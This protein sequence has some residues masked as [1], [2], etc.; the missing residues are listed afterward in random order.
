MKPENQ[1][2]TSSPAPSRYRRA[3]LG[4]LGSGVGLAIVTACGGGGTDEALIDDGSSNGD[5]GDGSAGSS[6]GGSSNGSC[7]EVNGETQGPFPADGSNGVNVLTDSRVVRSNIT[8]DLGGSNTQDGLPLYLT[9]TVV[10][11]DNSCAPLEGAAV[12]IW[13]CNADGEYSAYSGSGNG[14]H[15][16]ETFLRGVQ[17]TDGNGQV[18]FQTVYPGR[19]SGRATHIHCEVYADDSYNTLLK[20]TQFAFDDDTNDVVYASSNTYDDSEATR[21]TSN[22][23]DGI[24][25]DGYDDELLTLSGDTTNGYV[26]SI[27]IGVPT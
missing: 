7:T 15:S 27:V 4:W 12:Y 13:H 21:A 2:I 19:Y 26:A 11:V 3:L 25:S 14:S 20:T 18:T 17:I 1:T 6:S 5:S 24:F 23:Q 22:E 8:S 16:G 10:D 9:I